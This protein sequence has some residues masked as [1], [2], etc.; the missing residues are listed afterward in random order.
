MKKIVILMG[1]PGSGKGTQAQMLS[2]KFNYGHISTGDL[3]RNLSSDA[4]ADPKDKKLLANM[5]SGKLVPDKLVYKLAFTEIEKYL[6]RGQGIVLDGAIRSVEQAER[7]QKFFDEKGLSNEI[8]VIDVNIS[9]DTSLMRLQYRRDNSKQVRADDDLKVMKKRI[10][11]QGN[12]AILPILY[13]YE[14]VGV[15]KRVSGERPIEEVFKDIIDI[16]EAS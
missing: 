2:E 5:K 13:Y 6:G 7:F 14:G 12:K 8:V 10:K 4:N 16:L 1:V 3:L 15:L 9:D 11:E